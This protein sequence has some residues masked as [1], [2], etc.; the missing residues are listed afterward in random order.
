MLDS[1]TVIE[2]IGFL[3]PARSRDQSDSV[4]QPTYLL[5]PPWPPDH[6]VAATLSTCHPE[7]SEGTL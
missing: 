4:P 1:K 7:R 5:N 3:N 2:G 6:L